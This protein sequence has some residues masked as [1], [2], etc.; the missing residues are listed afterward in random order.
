MAYVPNV[1]DYAQPRIDAGRVR[2]TDAYY[3]MT[4]FQAKIKDEESGEMIPDPAQEPGA[5]TLE[6]FTEI[7]KINE[8]GQ[9]EGDPELKRYKVCAMFSDRDSGETGIP[10][11]IVDENDNPLFDPAN[12]DGVG[13]KGYAIDKTSERSKFKKAYML[14]IQ[15]FA[16][17]GV[18]FP[19]NVKELVGLEGVGITD[20]E[21]MTLD[22]RQNPG[23]KRDIEV[24]T[25]I[26]EKLDKKAGKKTGTAKPAAA[27]PAA[28]PA[29][30][31][32]K[33]APK[34]APEP[35]PEPEPEVEEQ[36]AEAEEGSEGSGDEA[37]SDNALA[38]LGA[39]IEGLQKEKKE[40]C[41]VSAVKARA[42]MLIPKIVDDAAI[43]PGVQALM[44]D[45]AW[46]TNQLGDM[47]IEVTGDGPKAQFS[48]PA[49]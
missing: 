9:P 4:Q 48:V 12:E 32:K 15:S 39:L 29:T 42:I 11:V 41:L 10:F 43:R 2:I 28:A 13:T 49:A 33:A 19:A 40:T 31:G 1:E 46:I 20:V 38:V 35:E 27:K 45:A 25:F 22:D 47:G 3:E 34:P 30:K 18:A 5:P 6:L 36:E 44:K 17:C 26:Y 7:V 16:K 14:L 8:S 21:K 24:R 23:K 37:V